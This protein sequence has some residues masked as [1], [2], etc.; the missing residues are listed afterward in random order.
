MW[1]GAWNGFQEAHRVLKR[2]GSLYVCGFSEI[3][4]DIKWAAAH[5]F[6]GCKWLI[7]FYRN[8]A[9]LGN[10][11][12]RSHESILHFRKSKDF[13]FNIDEVRIPY[14]EHTLKYP[15]RSQ[16]ET[17]QYANGKRR[18][19]VGNQTPWVQSLKMCLKYQLSLIAHGKNIPT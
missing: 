4:A 16:A 1:I 9:N 11:W 3:L 5:L 12:G 10:D 17:S 19:T 6:K 14:N 18:T 7:W 2:T 13:I 8:K 15:K